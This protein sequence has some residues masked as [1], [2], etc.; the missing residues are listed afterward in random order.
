MILCTWIGADDG[1]TRAHVMGALGAVL[2]STRAV[3]ASLAAL[4]KMTGLSK[5]PSTDGV[6][7]RAI[8]AGSGYGSSILE[9]L[10]LV[11]NA[12]ARMDCGFIFSLVMLLL[13]DARGSTTLPSNYNCE[14]DN[15]GLDTCHEAAVAIATGSCLL[16]LLGLV[17]DAKLGSRMARP[18][19]LG[20]PV[21][22]ML[23]RV[24][25]IGQMSTSDPTIM[26]QK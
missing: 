12:M 1:D 16:A 6:N 18:M 5:P 25:A 22:G 3:D 11:D 26:F 7:S 4:S 13:E 20:K 15:E 17:R 2:T 9:R 10:L 8:V 24:I 14:Y 23:A 19:N 21:M